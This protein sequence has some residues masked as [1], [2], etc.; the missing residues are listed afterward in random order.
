MA[1]KER[2]QI[3]VPIDGE[4][5]AALERAAKAEHRTVANLVRHIVAQALEN[6][7]VAA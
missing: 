2:E 3:S 5:K 6:Q 4:L 7:R 1:N